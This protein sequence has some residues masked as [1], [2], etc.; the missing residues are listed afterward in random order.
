VIY[1]L[2]ACPVGARATFPV[3]RENS[4]ESQQAPF[5]FGQCGA[6]FNTLIPSA[7]GT[8]PRGRTG[9]SR[10][11]ARKRYNIDRSM[12]FRAVIESISTAATAARA[13][14]SVQRSMCLNHDISTKLNVRSH[15]RS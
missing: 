14:G 9:Q 12:S 10:L 5:I 3:V 7:V 8:D 15:S 13:M 1:P 11:H 4:S 2:S 6:G